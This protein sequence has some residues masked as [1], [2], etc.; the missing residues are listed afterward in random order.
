MNLSKFEKWL[1]SDDIKEVRR[2][3]NNLHKIH[4]NHQKN[5]KRR[6]DALNFNDVGSM[7]FNE[8]AY[9]QENEIET[10]WLRL[11]NKYHDL[12]FELHGFNAY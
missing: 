3:C 11:N 10:M 12:H 6:C 2:Q 7:D 1:A 8:W 5:V 9:D 4:S